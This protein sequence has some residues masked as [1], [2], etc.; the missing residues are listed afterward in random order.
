M[1]HWG[2]VGGYILRSVHDLHLPEMAF[3]GV[4]THK[5]LDLTSPG[6][7]EIIEYA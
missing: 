7:P 2:Y 5:C 4:E 6:V 1:T 3:N